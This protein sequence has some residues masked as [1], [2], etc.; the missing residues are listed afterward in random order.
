MFD[1]I[2]PSLADFGVDFDVYFNERDLHETGAV[3]DAVAAAA[4]RRPC[5]RRRRR[6]LAAHHRLRRRQGPGDRQVATAT[7]DL[8]LLPTSPTTSTSASAASTRSSSCSAPTTTA[9]SPGCK[10]MVA[11]LGEDPDADAGDPDRPDGEPVAAARRMS[12]RAGNV[13]TLDD[14]IDGRR[15]RR[16]AGTPWCA[17]RLDSTLDLDLDLWASADQR[18]PGVLRAVRARPA[19]LAAAQ[20]RRPRHRPRHRLR[21][22]AAR[23]RA[24]GR[25]ARRAR[26]V[27]AG[28]RRRPR[29]CA[30]RTGSP[31]TS[32]SSPART[33]ASTTPAGCCRGATRW[34]PPLTVARLWLC[35]ATRT[36][37]ANG[38]GLLGVS[39]PERM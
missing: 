27:P 10:A 14:L 33:T 20:R 12:K 16:G 30:N 21:P 1:E 37:L 34:R 17:G 2:K 32:R 25:P 39:A 22:G 15:R 8:L 23:P 9:T 4:R 29:S 6:G 26:R 5:L 28:R 38:L 7:P 35:E 31:G 36:V 19:R 18:Q 11:G 24:G 13:V 3:D